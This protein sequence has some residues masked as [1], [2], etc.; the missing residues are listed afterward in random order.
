MVMEDI[1]YLKQ[2]IMLLR[3]KLK[4]VEEIR[5]M[6]SYIK[7]DI[8]HIGVPN[9]CFSLTDADDEREKG[10]SEQRIERGF[11]NSELWNLNT[12][13]AWFVFPR[14]KAFREES[15][16]YP[17]NLSNEEW[18][19]ILQKMERSFEIVVDDNMDEAVAEEYKE[20]MELFTKWF[21]AL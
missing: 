10:Y 20:G 8:K 12:T 5:R 14:L 11:D 15:C 16:G 18:D 2:Q 21:A 7:V 1:K 3:K 4:L 6:Q 17:G 9:I 19:A 13:I